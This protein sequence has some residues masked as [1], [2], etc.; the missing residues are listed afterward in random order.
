LATK[1]LVS[2]GSARRPTRYGSSFY[3]V[4]GLRKVHGHAANDHHALTEKSNCKPLYLPG[5]SFQMK[6]LPPFSKV[7]ILGLL[8]L[9]AA[10]AAWFLC[11]PGPPVWR[12]RTIFHIGSSIDP[13]RVIN[14]TS[15]GVG[16]IQRHWAVIALISNPTFRDIIVG[17]SEFHRDSAALSRRLVFAT[18]RPHELDNNDEDVEIDLTA[19]SAADCLAAY[20]AIAHQ[21][22]Q[23]HASRFDEN[24]RQ[25]QAAIDDYRE[26]SMQLKKWEDAALQP[27][28]PDSTKSELSKHDLA[29]AWSETR[30]RLRRLEAAKLVLKP[31][32]FPPESEVYV[33]GPL[34]NNTVRLSALAGLA[35]LLCT[36][37]LTL[38]LEFRSSGR[39]TRRT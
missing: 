11:R 4:S 10:V 8:T 39:R 33:N 12:L 21:I 30:E 13:A 25:L 28:V 15:S 31:T 5:I 3:P 19:A 24:A 23:R 36:L 1:P 35:V 34:T 22:E 7:L 2:R 32:T 18:L 16:T 38:G 27:D 17:T 6:K 14:G 20:R 26:R 9:C 29:V 37:L